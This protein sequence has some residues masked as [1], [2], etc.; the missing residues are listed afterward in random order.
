MV[1]SGAGTVSLSEEYFWSGTSQ[2]K[3]VL[4]QDTE[5]QPRGFPM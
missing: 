4:D 1:V 5:S 3:V 2:Y